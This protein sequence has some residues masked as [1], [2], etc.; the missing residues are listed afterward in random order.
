MRYRLLRRRAVRFSTYHRQ[1]PGGQRLAIFIIVN[2]LVFLTAFS[3]IVAQLRPIMLKLAAAKVSEA[4][5]YSINSLIDDEISKGTFDYNKL[6]TLEK[7]NDGNITALVTN[8]ALVNMLQAR[9]SKNIL[10]TIR[11][12]IV[13]DLK[14]PIGNAVGG[15]I[16]SG[17]GP[18]FVVKVLSV[19]N[20]STKFTND[21]S[22]AGIN[23]TRHKI[24]LDITVGLD[25]FVSGTKS[26]PHTVTD[27][28]EV[29]ET[30]IVG[31]VPSVY[32]DLGGGS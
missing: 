19:A 25:I 11:N 5:L 4:I 3:I 16:F 31:K 6:V 8:M 17:R 18:S 32:A 13:T 2:I 20:V 12:D 23:Q 1:L 22:S 10:S 29:C 15:V 24:M 9:I 7:D 27:E 21:F 28:V 30:V 26:V 14:I